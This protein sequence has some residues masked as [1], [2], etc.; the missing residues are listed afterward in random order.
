MLLSNATQSATTPQ[1]SPS[2]CRSRASRP[3]EISQ[4][5][6][7]AANGAKSVVT[8]LSEVASAAAETKKSAQKVLTASES[9]EMAAAEMRGEVECFRAKVAI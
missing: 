9:V 4:N 2:Q 6:T 3:G 7:S 5:V 8:V 1:P